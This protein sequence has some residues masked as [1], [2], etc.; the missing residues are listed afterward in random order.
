MSQAPTGTQQRIAP[1]DRFED[2]S[3][4]EIAAL[5]EDYPT[6]AATGAL[7]PRSARILRDRPEFRDQRVLACDNP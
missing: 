1:I 4:S 7:T 5:A 6:F 3:A 2:L